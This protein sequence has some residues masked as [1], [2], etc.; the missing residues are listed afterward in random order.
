M[1]GTPC[2]CGGECMGVCY[3]KIAGNFPAER[4]ARVYR[5]FS[6]VDWEVVLFR[7]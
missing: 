2:A 1:S 3:I 6:N 5:S 4:W 7:F